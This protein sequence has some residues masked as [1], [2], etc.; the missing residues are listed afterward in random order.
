MDVAGRPDDWRNPKRRSFFPN[1]GYCGFCSFL[2]NFAADRLLAHAKQLLN[3]D[4]LTITIISNRLGFDYPQHFVRF[5]KTH[6]GK[7]PSAYRKVS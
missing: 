7:T 1:F 6:T 3:D 4:K 2:H 5:F